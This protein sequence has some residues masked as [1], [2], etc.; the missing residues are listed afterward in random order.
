MHPFCT[1]SDVIRLMT[2][3]L[4]ETS[5]VVVPSEAQIMSSWTRFDAPA[6]TLS[7]ASG[8]VAR[9]A[10]LRIVRMAAVRLF[11][12]RLRFEPIRLDHATQPQ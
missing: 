7:K 11:H 10:G 1:T 12:H 3:S 2:P 5:E 8:C 4:S 6:R 9:A